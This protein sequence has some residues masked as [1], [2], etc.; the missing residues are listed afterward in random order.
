MGEE[1]GAVGSQDRLGEAL[2]ACLQA[3]EAG[4]SPQP[5]RDRFPEFAGEI[6]EFLVERA[7]FDR[8]A[9]PIRAAVQ[10]APTPPAP[11][12]AAGAPPERVGQMLGDYRLLEEIGR[13]G[14][15]VVYKAQQ[16]SLNRLVALKLI[17]SADL[18]SAAEAT[19]FRNEAEVVAHL[20]HPN[21]VPIHEV[22]Q[23]GALLYFS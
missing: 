10:A 5:V 23:E 22:G 15:G 20:D 8:L 16:L 9:A 14:M 2:F 11:G 13:G 17:R 6:A 21:V 19:R 12:R 3:L 4:E 1:H 7:G 18:A